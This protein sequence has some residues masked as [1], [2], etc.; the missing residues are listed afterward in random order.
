MLGGM[1]SKSE[2]FCGEMPA[3]I[4]ETAAEYFT[5]ADL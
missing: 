3:A 4:H 2:L 5:A 1:M